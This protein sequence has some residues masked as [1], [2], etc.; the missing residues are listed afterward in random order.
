MSDTIYF[1]GREISS[2][3]EPV[4]ENELNEY[5]IYYIVN[6]IDEKLIIPVMRTV[7][8]VGKNLEPDDVNSFY[9]QDIDSYHEGKG[10]EHADIYEEFFVCSAKELNSVYDLEHA[11]ERLM[12]CFLQQKKD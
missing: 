12:Y 4:S 2:Y 1:E 3:G 11:L 8:F 5:S 6:F 7:V 10:Y 9:F